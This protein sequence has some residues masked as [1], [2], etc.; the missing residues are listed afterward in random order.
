MNDLR[1]FFFS[2]VAQKVGNKSNHASV[3]HTTLTTP[4]NE[5]ENLN[6]AQIDLK[7]GETRK[8]TNI[9]SKNKKNKIK[10]TTT[11]K[12]LIMITLL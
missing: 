10:S 1:F 4:T 6:V 11:T 3:G 7:A 5:K 2:G 12:K 8:L 9:K